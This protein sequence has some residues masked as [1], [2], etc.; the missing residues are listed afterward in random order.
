MTT[1]NRVFLFALF[2]LAVAPIFQGCRPCDRSGCESLDDR[3]S[4]ENITQGLSGTGACLSDT[5]DCYMN[6]C[7][8]ECPV[9]HVG[10]RIWKAGATAIASPED[11]SALCESREPDWTVEGNPRYELS[12]EP[13]YYLACSAGCMGFGVGSGQVTTLNI[14]YGN[15]SSS[16]YM[17]EPGGDPGDGIESFFLDC[18][19]VDQDQ[20]M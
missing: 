19:P 4:P 15:G 20:A 9:C 11:A 13:G 12:L 18:V 16:F 8:S 17:S 10:L 2:Y 3:A 14:G 6:D 5:V 7:C 1:S